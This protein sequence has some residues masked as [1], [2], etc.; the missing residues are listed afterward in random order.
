MNTPQYLPA[1]DIAVPEAPRRFLERVANIAEVSGSF[2]VERHYDAVGTPGFD[3]LNLRYLKQLPHAK[4]G[5]QLIARPEL[6]GRIAVEMRAQTWWPDPPTYDSYC[7]AARSIIGPLLIAYNRE[8]GTKHRLRIQ[9]PRQL[10]PKLP[11]RSAKLFKTF[12]VLANTSSLH[13]LDWRR[14]YEFVRASRNQ[15]YEEELSRLLVKEGF[16]KS[17]AGRIAEIYRHLCE[18]KRSR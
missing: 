2:K 4:V 6:K 13:S 5:G 12:A 3:V 1:I 11:P 8:V 15:L 14:F 9:N 7:C 17:Y 10:E 16:S 18:F